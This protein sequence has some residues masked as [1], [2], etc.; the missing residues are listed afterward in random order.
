MA[1]LSISL[2]SRILLFPSRRKSNSAIT[3][4]KSD[5]FS[6][7]THKNARKWIVHVLT[8]RGQKHPIRYSVCGPGLCKQAN[9]TRCE[10]L[11]S[12]F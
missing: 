3:T 6:D 7:V 9:E 5:K 12:F 8:A 4:V 10:H 1:Q 2:S 11:L